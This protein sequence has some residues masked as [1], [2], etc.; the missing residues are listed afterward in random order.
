[1]AKTA[2]KIDDVPQEKIALVRKM[3]RQG[4][5]PV[6]AATAV[7]YPGTTNQFV[8]VA[9]KH[10]HIEFV[11]NWKRAHEGHLHDAVTA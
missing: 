3:A 11:K 7:G 9:R 5:P 10:W 4:R 2:F 6:E 1:M 8:R